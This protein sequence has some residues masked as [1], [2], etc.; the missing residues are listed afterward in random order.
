MNKGSEKSEPLLFQITIYR[1]LTPNFKMNTDTILTTNH[2][3][4]NKP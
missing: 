4:Q 3:L 2:L 1:N